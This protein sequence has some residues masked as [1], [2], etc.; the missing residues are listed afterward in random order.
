M[1]KKYQIDHLIYASS[2]SVYGGNKKL[3]F[4]EKDAVNH[5]VGLCAATKSNELMA[6]AYSHIYNLS[7]TGLRFF[8]VYGPWGGQI[9]LQ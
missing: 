7:C 6:N 8:T 1:S 9:W 5:P 4:S 3:P 2:S